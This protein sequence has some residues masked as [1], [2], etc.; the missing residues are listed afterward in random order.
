M[1]L[2]N[3]LPYIL[4]ALDRGVAIAA[5]NIHN[6]ETLQAVTEG[7]ARLRAP[8]I[9][10]TSPGTLAHM[11]LAYVAACCRV[12]SDQY[13]VPIALHMDHCRDF[14]TLVRC[15]QAGY[16]SLMVDAS[17]LPFAENVALT[18]RVVAMGRAAG[19]PVEAEL[20]R[21]GG[22]EDELTV[23]ER[24]ATMTDPGQAEEFVRATGVDTLAVAIGTA[25]GV[26]RGEPRLDFAR[27]SA[28]RGRVSVPLVLHGASGVPDG[29][30]REALRRGIAKVN[31]ATELKLPMA[32]AIRGAL[33]DPGQ[34]DP[35]VY[36]GR[37]RDAVREVVERKIR[38]CGCDGLAD[39]P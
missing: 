26:Y 37:A 4:K 38:L 11:G 14:D 28:I 1:P 29:A 21:V 22:T 8:V 27:L 19:I 16:T 3:P 15:L 25:H 10:Q 30:V 34:S 39:S 36:L 20:G 23:D 32:A 13:D 17:H 31:I 2:V 33:A 12:A 5:F 35:R 9:V 18:R 6:L 24:S 7:A